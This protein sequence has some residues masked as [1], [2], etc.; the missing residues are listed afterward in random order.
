MVGSLRLSIAVSLARSVPPKVPSVPSVAS[1]LDPTVPA[2]TP[3]AL[4]PL[5][6]P[7]L[8]LAP[9]PEPP[10]PAP[11]RSPNL[12]PVEP[13][14][15]LASL[16]VPAVPNPPPVACSLPPPAP[17]PLSLPVTASNAPSA[18]FG[19]PRRSASASGSRGIISG[20]PVPWSAFGVSASCSPGFAI[21]VSSSSLVHRLRRHQCHCF[22]SQR[23][24]RSSFWY[25]CL[26]AAHAT[27]CAASSRVSS[28]RRFGGSRYSFHALLYAA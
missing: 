7:T 1:V 23:P 14:A 13:V 19:W 6:A 20:M 16:S 28:P 25:S 15:L 26:T 11:P 2:P 24:V 8:G 4:L 3:C 12:A 18:V 9:P 27:L 17:D 22:G 21:S 10:Q 5:S